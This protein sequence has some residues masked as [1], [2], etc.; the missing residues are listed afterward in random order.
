MVFAAKRFT[1]A[2]PGHVAAF[3]AAQQE[4][5]TLIAT[6]PAEATR[7]FIQ[8][9]GSKVDPAEIT[10]VLRDP[11]TKFDTLPHG[12]MQ[13]AAF[14]QRAG[15]IKTAPHDWHDAFVPQLEGNGS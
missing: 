10:E 7:L 4:A 14:M 6:D 3:L 1:A 9:S 5:N 15:T 11:Q 12:F 2:N 13:Y 8:N